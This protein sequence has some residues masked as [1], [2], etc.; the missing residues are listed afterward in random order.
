MKKKIFE[1]KFI[2]ISIL[3]SCN[4]I[5]QNSHRNIIISS[6]LLKIPS[7]VKNYKRNFLV[8]SIN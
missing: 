8:I 1:Q 2:L 6:L 7:K 4:V 5:L 3:S